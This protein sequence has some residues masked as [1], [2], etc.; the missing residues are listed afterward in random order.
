[1]GKMYRLPDHEYSL[2]FG[3]LSLIYRRKRI[4]HVVET[5]CPAHNVH[6]IADGLIDVAAFLENTQTETRQDSQQ[7]FQDVRLDFFKLDPSYFL[8]KQ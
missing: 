1:M 5:E 4:L 6:L 2:L 7:M 3:M 8:G